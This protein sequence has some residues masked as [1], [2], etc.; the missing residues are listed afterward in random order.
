MGNKEWL[1]GDVFLKNFYTI[2]DNK[3]KEVTIGPH[4]T[5]MAGWHTTATIPAPKNNFFATDALQTVACEFSEA[6][7]KL[8]MT[9]VLASS[10]TWATLT[11]M[12]SV[13]GIDIGVSA[14]SLISSFLG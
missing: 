3:K 5:S 10:T 14:S 13:L 11:F 2:W 8:G 9:T 12:K 4:K 1:L 6:V 7:S